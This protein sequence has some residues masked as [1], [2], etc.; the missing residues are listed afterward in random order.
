[1][2]LPRATHDQLTA[3]AVFD[4]PI[5]APIAA[6]QEVGKVVISAPGMA[7]MEVP[8][9]AGKEVRKLGFFGRMIAALKHFVGAGA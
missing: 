6:G 4:G 7:D 3:K 5:P 9:V 8:L 2:T 1:V